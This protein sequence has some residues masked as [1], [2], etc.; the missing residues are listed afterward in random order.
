MPLNSRATT[1]ATISGDAAPAWRLNRTTEADAVA[2]LVSVAPVAHAA[3]VKLRSP[4]TLAH[5][6]RLQLREADAAAADIAVPAVAHATLIEDGGAVAHSP[7]IHRRVAHANPGA[8]GRCGR[9]PAHATAI[10]ARLAAASPLA[11]R[12]GGAETDVAAILVLE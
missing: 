1:G 6:I 4:T 10:D 7:A 5:A 3:V 11:V 8:V 12:S 9:V 2:A